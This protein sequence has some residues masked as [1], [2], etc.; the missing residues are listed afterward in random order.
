MKQLIVNPAKEQVT[1][2][3]VIQEAEP[4][5]Y[6][7]TMTKRQLMFWYTINA[8]LAA[9]HEEAM[10]DEFFIDVN[11]VG[12]EFKDVGCWNKDVAHAVDNLHTVYTAQ[13]KSLGLD[14]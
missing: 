13:L 6:T 7:V 12:K 4:E 3:K 10:G 1:E 9:I 11:K 8:N 5:S 2:I 14:R